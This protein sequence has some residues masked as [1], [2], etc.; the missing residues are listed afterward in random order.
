MYNPFLYV[1]ISLEF[2]GAIISLIILICLM[3]GA[4]RNDSLNIKYMRMLLCNI[5]VL[6]SD[7]FAGIFKGIDT[8]LAF[9]IVRAANFL[10]FSVSYIFVPLFTDYMTAFIRQKVKISKIIVSVMYAMCG[11]AVLLVI[12]SQF[13]HI[14]YGFEEPN[15]YQRQSLFW[16]SQALGILFLLIN[17]AVIIRYIGFIR[18]REAL[19]LLSYALLPR[20][21][22][23]I[24]IFVYALALLYI[25]TTVSLMLIYVGIQSRQA[26][27]S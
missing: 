26:R 24:Q 27:R 10:V 14:Y 2:L 7:A 11:F 9:V 17:A 21:A 3:V 12:V 4:N 23:G 19:L 13:T 8:P 18:K 6:V 25:A 5:L 20:A 16:L 1:N 15:M 22:M